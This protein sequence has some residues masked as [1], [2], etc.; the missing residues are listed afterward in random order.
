MKDKIE[1]L[2]ILILAS[3]LILFSVIY[4]LFESVVMRNNYLKDKL[5][6]R[7]FNLIDSEHVT[8]F[9]KWNAEYESK[10]K[11]QNDKD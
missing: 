3:P 11:E 9:I 7:R 6:M 5:F 4:H 8:D 10:R 1:D 2:V